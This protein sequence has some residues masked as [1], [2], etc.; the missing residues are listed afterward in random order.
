MDLPPFFRHAKKMALESN[1]EHRVG[2]CVVKSGRVLSVGKNEVNKTN[3]ITKVYFEYPTVHAEC[4][5]LAKLTPEIIRGAT[6]YVYREKWTKSPGLAKPCTH[7]ARVL[8][9]MGI[10]RVYYTTNDAPFFACLDPQ[11]ESVAA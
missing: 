2:A 5:A 1:Q 3:W 6:V 10:R 4:S 11:K 7:C 9:E 8:A